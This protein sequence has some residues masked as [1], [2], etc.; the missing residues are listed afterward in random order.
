MQGSFVAHFPR[1]DAAECEPFLHITLMYLKPVRP[2]VVQLLDDGRSMWGRKVLSVA[3]ND[4][5]DTLLCLNEI[6]LMQ[7]LDLREKHTLRIFKLVSFDRAVTLFVPGEYLLIDDLSK[8]GPY[9]D[10][11]HEWWSGAASELAKERVREAA[12]Q[13]QADARRARQ[14]AGESRQKAAW[15]SGGGR[16]KR[17][18]KALDSIKA[19][20]APRGSSV[21]PRSL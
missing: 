14:A 21:A 20:P 2:T 13:A 10:A 18:Q 7:R 15:R 8:T 3:H 6:E 9:E 12:K 19:S 1:M 16:R 5:E 17:Q 4:G 11:E